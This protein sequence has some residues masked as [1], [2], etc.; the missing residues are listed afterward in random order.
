MNVASTLTG[1]L[2]L[3]IGLLATS[4]PAAAGQTLNIHD[5]ATGVTWNLTA[6]NARFS[7]TEA[8]GL[9]QVQVAADTGAFWWMKFGAP[10]GEKLLPGTYAHAGCPGGVRTG[11]AP[12]L[13]V[14]DNPICLDHDIVWGQFVIR[15]IDYDRRGRV[16]SV[17][18]TFS[19]RQHSPT[20]P[21]LVGELRMDTE[22]LSLTMNS[23]KSFA[24]GRI[25]QENHGDTS[26]FTL[27]G[28]TA[29]IDY[30]A[31]V[32]KDFWSM[33]I[34]PPEGMRLEAGRSYSTRN[35][36][37]R[38]N[39]GLLILRGVDP[40]PGCPDATGLLHVRAMETGPGGEVLGL[41]AD[42]HYKC[43]LKSPPLRGTIRYHL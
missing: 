31:S 21:A 24:W 25:A 15:Q 12:A 42:F 6:D 8:V 2:C 39:A 37:N 7:M 28:T 26:L 18:L 23:P 20:A 10:P 5:E 17:E 14:T 22:P 33:A 36:P 41:H 16:R 9:L 38:R 32:I 1:S 13:E 11:R 40:G 19:Q 43:A 27:T 3:G 4:A 35:F 30:T 34:Q 29:G